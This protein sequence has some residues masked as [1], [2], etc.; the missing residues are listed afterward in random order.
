LPVRRDNYHI[1]APYDGVYEE[2][3][4]SDNVKY[5]GSGIENGN[6]IVSSEPPMHGCEQSISLTLPPLSVIY[7]KCRRKKPK[8]QISDEADK[9]TAPSRDPAEPHR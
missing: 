5:G 7:L 3:F 9:K 6:N 4:S 8:P 1:G 2:V